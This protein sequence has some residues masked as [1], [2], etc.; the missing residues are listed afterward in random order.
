LPPAMAHASSPLA[1]ARAFG[2][3]VG[4]L[5]A[6]TARR[7]LAPVAVGFASSASELVPSIAPGV[8][9]QPSMLT[10]MP[11]VPTP[12]A[13]VPPA[14]TPA[15]ETATL[16]NGVRIATEN[17]DGPM[18]AAGIYADVGSMHEAP[19][20]SGACHLL[21]KLAFK[22][23]ANR[24]HFRFVR[25]MEAIGVGMAA[26]ASREQL[27]FHAD[28]LRAFTPEVV[29]MLA[30]AVVNPAFLPWEITAEVEK[31]KLELDDLDKNPHQQIIEGAHMAAFTG[32]LDKPLVAPR[33]QL[34]VL[35]KHPEIVAEFY[36]T[37]MCGKR[38]AFAASGASA[39]EMARLLEPTLGALPA[40]N[41]TP[42]D[43][44]AYVGGEVKTNAVGMG[45][46]VMLAFGCPGWRDVKGSVGVTV[47]NVLM[48]GGGSFSSGGPGKGMHSRLYKRVLQKNASIVNCSF[49]NSMFNTTGFAGILISSGE[50]PASHLVDIA[51]AELL[52]LAKPGAL[53]EE[54]VA[55]A[56]ASAIS[57]VLFNL[58]SKSIAAEDIGRQ[59]LTYGAKKDLKEYVDAVNALTPKALQELAASMMK[60]TPTLVSYGDVADMPRLSMIESR[61][62]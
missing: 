11:G 53:T 25:E 33:H 19:Y 62:K 22:S 16:P 26:A 31:M 61:F 56:K 29:E 2:S 41:P 36:Q 57:A 14:T 24:T 6:M 5:C 58:E 9:S 7:N 32:G 1:L 34:D 47:L 4:P 46:N 27:V 43:G 48:G 52:E 20:Q 30:D 8:S 21:E 40:G 54:E 23:T 49:V 12:P 59:V 10:P 35:A 44:S 45:A 39:G 37:N 28:A 3:L 55:R 50:T 38:I 13:Y 60:S 51:S 18:I 17:T 15:T 42:A